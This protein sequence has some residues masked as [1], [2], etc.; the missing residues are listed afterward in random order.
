MT[1][2]V[3]H[4]YN[5]TLSHLRFFKPPLIDMVTTSDQFLRLRAR[6]TDIFL[7]EPRW[8]NLPDQDLPNWRARCEH[9]ITLLTQLLSE[10]DD[11]DQATFYQS[12][13]NFFSRRRRAI[14]GEMQRRTNWRVSREEEILGDDLPL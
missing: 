9:E 2:I 8:Q 13:L 14:D 10:S 5:Y 3:R 11:T 7:H 6:Y 4:S 12:S 1:Y